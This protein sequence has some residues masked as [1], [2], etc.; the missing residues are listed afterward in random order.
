MALCGLWSNLELNKMCTLHPILFKN[1]I[2]IIFWSITNFELVP[3]TYTGILAILGEIWE[4]TQNP[5]EIKYRFNLNRF[6]LKLI[7]FNRQF[8]YVH[9][10][11]VKIDP[12]PLFPTL[13][14]LVNANFSQQSHHKR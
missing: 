3:Q 14:N 1:T 7:K 4:I 5:R 9:Q 2:L 13:H 11:L 10:F 8:N 12:L 6:V